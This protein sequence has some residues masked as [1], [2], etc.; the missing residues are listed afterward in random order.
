VAALLL[1]L[2]LML[3]PHLVA[4]LTGRSPWPHRFLAL[5]GRIA[6]LRVRIAGTP[7]RR[8]VF[9]IANHVSWTDILA[10][11][12]ATGCAFVSK[13]DVGR[14]PLIGWL[15]AQNNTILV[16]RDRRA[17][18]GDQIAAMRRAIAD[19]QPVTLFPE[20]TTGD[21][22]TLLP[23]K[24]TLLATLLPPPRDIRVQPV[25]IDYGD[26]TGI[27]A[28]HGDESAGAIAARIT[29]HHAPIPV[30]LHFLDPIDPAAFADR[31]ALAAACRAPIA[32]ALASSA[33][34]RATI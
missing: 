8:D 27:V 13:D 30:T 5:A 1:A 6:G 14:W 19:H 34:A 28:W 4:R 11:G 22:R 15:A 25:L 23:F 9:Y 24:P 2:L 12:G 31:K 10:L 17:A 33:P 18:I 29:G 7:L 32:A 26:A 16:A 21:G 20:G 3:P